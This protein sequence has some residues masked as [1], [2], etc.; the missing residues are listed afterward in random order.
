MRIVDDDDDAS[1]LLTAPARQLASRAVRAALR[2]ERA[3][4]EGVVTK[5]GNES[6][7]RCECETSSSSPPTAE[8]DADTAA[9]RT[10]PS[11]RS[12]AATP[13]P[14]ADETDDRDGSVGVD[15]GTDTGADTGADSGADTGA[16]SGADT[17]RTRDSCSSE[18]RAVAAYAEFVAAADADDALA[19]ARAMRA[20]AP[21]PAFEPLHL[22]RH[23]RVSS[24]RV[25]AARL[26][27]AWRAL[28][29]PFAARVDAAIK[30]S[31]PPWRA[32]FAEA[33]DAWERA[34]AAVV[35]RERSVVRLE[36]LVARKREGEDDSPD[37]DE[38][39]AFAEVEAATRDVAR[40]AH[41]LRAFDETLRV[42]GTPYLAEFIA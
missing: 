22:E 31:T 23:P 15:S 17:P 11:G 13:P 19:A 1:T 35:A 40:A 8:K 25:A 38:I 6:D 9:A 18:T 20:R 10:S 33:L 26:E 37:S 12:S 29:T 3:A 5:E 24:S 7:V 21:E 14:T 28:Q 42:Q 4:T 36:A 41:T 30:F 2:R 32:M 39:E 16:D 34:A 27:R